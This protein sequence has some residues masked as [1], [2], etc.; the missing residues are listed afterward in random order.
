MVPL[1][2]TFS[3]LGGGLFFI[4]SSYTQT[5]GFGLSAGAVH[6]FGVDP[7]PLNT[8]IQKFSG[9][10]FSA[11]V[12]AGAATSFFACAVATVNGS[13]RI[14]F[15]LARDGY[16]PKPLAG[17]HERSN[18]PRAAV[19]VVFPLGLALLGL[20]VLLFN[21]PANVL[22][23]M[24]GL[25]A[26]GALIAYGLVVIASLVEYGRTDLAERKVFA[27]ALPVIGLVL[28]GWILY[29]SVYPVPSS[30]VNF[31]PYVTL[32]YFAAVL[33]L[34]LWHRKRTAPESVSANIESGELPDVVSVD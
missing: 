22:G 24:S 11:L 29:S 4:F 6:A 16:A 5:L 21:T 25:G 19:F 12:N 32:A 14:L 20:G 18:T 17:L 3:A 1:A 10:T 31:F 7:A 26:F 2:I 8:L 15:A 13:A 9:T 30:P 28:I 33:P 23:D 34:S 27:L